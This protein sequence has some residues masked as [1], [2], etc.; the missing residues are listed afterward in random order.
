MDIKTIN[1]AIYDWI[2][3]FTNTKTIWRN[4][5]APSP[6]LP[7]ITL[8]I[9]SLLPIGTDSFIGVDGDGV[10]TY[11]G[12]NSFSLQV[13][14]FGKDGLS[15]LE[16]LLHS[17]NDDFYHTI[18]RTA[19]LSVLKYSDIKDLTFLQDTK[20]EKRFLLDISMLLGSE[21]TVTTEYIESVEMTGK[22]HNNLENIIEEKFTI[23]SV[24]D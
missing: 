7:Y 10:S 15:V 8:Y 1:K 12:N 19:G 18:L 5:N 9:P 24:T 2:S 6:A 22:I 23:N 14:Y 3:Q 16:S 17:M 21:Y 11:V 20:Y 4:E 13:E